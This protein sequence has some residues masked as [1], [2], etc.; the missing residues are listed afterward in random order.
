ME[1]IRKMIVAGNIFFIMCS[2]YGD[3]VTV[4]WY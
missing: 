4:L 1:L 2:N 3:K